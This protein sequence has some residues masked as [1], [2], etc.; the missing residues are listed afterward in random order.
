MVVNAGFFLERLPMWVIVLSA[1]IA[2]FNPTPGF[3][4]ISDCLRLAR[5]WRWDRGHGMARPSR[6]LFSSRTAGTF[7]GH[8]L[9]SW[10]FDRRIGG[11]I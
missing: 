10:R 9:L 3:V 8:V 5:I 6:P 7:H 1:L 2:A 11:R 4:C